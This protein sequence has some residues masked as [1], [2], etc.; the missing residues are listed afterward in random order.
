MKKIISFVLGASVGAWAAHTITKYFEP[1]RKEKGDKYKSYYNMLT[2]W[3]ELEEEGN[4]VDYLLKEPGY[5]KIA[6]YGMGNIGK[7]LCSVLKETDVEVV[8]GIDSY[9]ENDVKDVTVFSINDE[10]PEV[11]AIIVTIPFAFTEIQENLEKKVECP[12]VSLEHI[13]FEL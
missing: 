1:P 8:C 7:H 6:V 11:D 5:E 2:K 9:A 4:P 10:L 13:L 3:L 12:I